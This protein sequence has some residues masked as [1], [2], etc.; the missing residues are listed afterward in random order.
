MKNLLLLYLGIC[1][2]AISLKYIIRWFR[3]LAGS[4]TKLH[5]HAAEHDMAHAI[6]FIIL[7]IIGLLLIFFVNNSS[8]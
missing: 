5:S 8:A 7:M 1:V 3:L 4:K 2:L 6:K